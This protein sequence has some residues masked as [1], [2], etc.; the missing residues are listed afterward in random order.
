MAHVTTLND[1]AG[2]TFA[3]VPQVARVLR[4]DERTIRRGIEA[5]RIPGQKVGS[6]WAVPVSWLREQAGMPEPSP[7]VDELADQVA[8][9]VLA[10]LAGLFTRGQDAEADGEPEGDVKSTRFCPHHNVRLPGGR[11]E[12]EARGLSLAGRT[13]LPARRT[14][15]ND[16]DIDQPVRVT[17][18]L[19]R[20]IARTLSGP[21]GYPGTTA[22]D[23]TRELGKARDDGRNII[24]LFAADSIQDALEAGVLAR[25]SDGIIGQVPS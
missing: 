12:A 2:Q 3:D 14:I 18:D 21:H 13:T 25:D 22:E 15:I 9:R 5:G 17:P 24:G 6:K 10:R 23:V 7:D 19:A 8:D 11:A 16:I 4:R 1:L 20:A